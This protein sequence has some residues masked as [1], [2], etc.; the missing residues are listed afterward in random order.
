MIRYS[1]LGSGSSG[2]SYIIGYNR[3][4]ILIDAGYSLRELRRRVA[5]TDLNFEDIHGVCITHL[6]P[7]HARGAGVFARQTGK[8]IYVN[9]NLLEKNGAALAKLGIPAHLLRTFECHQS[10]DLGDFSITA[11][12]TRHDSPHSVGFSVKIGQRIFGILTDTGSIDTEMQAY[13]READILFLEANY[14]WPMLENGPYP[15]W[16][17]QRISGPHGHLSNDDAINFLNSCSVQTPQK[18]YFCHLS[19]NNN[20]PDFLEQSCNSS[21]IWNGIRTICHHGAQYCG[22]LDTGD[23]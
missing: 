19:K 6:H 18:V 10:F 11:Y 22:S 8:S 4:A 13:A 21:L 17:K 20:H 12:P 14:D 7:D 9:A 15:Y 23:N 1:V 2:N 5:L 3:G 16:L